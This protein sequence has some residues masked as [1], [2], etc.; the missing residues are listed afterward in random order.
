MSI[1]TMQVLLVED[2]PADVAL[3]RRVFSEF[4]QQVWRC[5]GVETLDEAITTY[6]RMSDVMEE[7]PCNLVLLDLGLP[8]AK[9]LQTI[10][11]FL[12]AEPKAP[13]VVLSGNDDEALALQ[14]IEQGAQDYLVKDQVT[15][16]ALVKSIQFAIRRQF[17]LEQLRQ[18]ID[19]NQQTLLQSQKLN[20]QQTGFVGMVLHEIRNP[21]GIIQ[22]SVEMIQFNLEADIYTRV[23]KWLD[24]IQ[25]ANDQVIYLLDDVLA[26]C[27]LQA[28][29]PRLQLSFLQL[30][31][32]CT[33]LVEEIQH[34]SGSDHIIELTMQTGLS[35]T[36]SDIKLL[37]SILTNLLSNAIKYTPQGGIIRFAVTA[38]NH[39]IT[40]LIQDT[41]IGIPESDQSQLFKQFYRASNVG[42]IAGTGLG[43]AI[44]ERCVNLLQGVVA[45]DSIVGCGTTFSVQLPLMQATSDS[46]HCL[47]DS[48]EQR[49]LDV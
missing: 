48:L 19:V 4:P 18:L 23:Q 2:N 14:A 27:R 26:L 42:Q 29:E 15:L 35:H 45:V 12:A 1:Q 25:V 16:K 21:L 36:F 6:R 31:Q 38:A 3:V 41:G 28:E 43:L 20:Q 5:V 22:M 34:S 8:D 33:E 39:W 9:G 17:K 46:S 10:Q 13:V 37:R 7:N 11:Q 24:K 30:P 47:G 40:F 32:F 44:V 49:S